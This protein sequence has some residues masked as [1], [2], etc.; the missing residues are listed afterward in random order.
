MY[1]GIE[2]VHERIVRSAGSMEEGLRGQGF[3]FDVVEILGDE[4]GVVQ[5]VELNPFGA[6]TGCGSCLFQWV[7]DAEVL[8]GVMGE[9]V[10]FRVAVNDGMAARLG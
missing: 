7:R 4:G 6:M 1:A 9:K 10:E 5:L 3:T 8:Y 2:A